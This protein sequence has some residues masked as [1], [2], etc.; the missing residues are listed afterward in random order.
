MPSR[1]FCTLPHKSPN[2][3]ADFRVRPW[4]FAH[5]FYVPLPSLLR[6]FFFLSPRMWSLLR[7]KYPQKIQKPK[8]LAG[9]KKKKKSLKA[10]QG[11]IK[12]VCKYFKISQNGVDIGTW[13]NL[14]FY[15]WTSLYQNATTNKCDNS[16]TSIIRKTTALSSRWMENKEMHYYANDLFCVRCRWL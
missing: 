10:R 5:V 3:H 1:D 2:V 6:K 13:R 4:H 12:H 14:G 16:S 15:A 11:H 9:K 8:Y 7:P